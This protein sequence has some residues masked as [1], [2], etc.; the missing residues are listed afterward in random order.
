MYQCN[1]CCYAPELCET[2][3]NY[4]KLYKLRE[5]TRNYAKLCDTMRNYAKLCGTMRNYC[6][7]TI[8]FSLL[9]VYYCI[10]TIVFLLLYFYYCIFL[11]YLV[12]PR[13]LGPPK[14]NPNR[15]GPGP[16]APQAKTK[17][18]RPRTLGPSS[19]TQAGPA[20][21]PWPP[22][23]KPSHSIGNT[24]GKLIKLINKQVI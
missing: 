7:C 5:T 24:I 11:F 22:K 15:S 16:L 6:I 1:L 10:F 19:Q 17:P 3:R 21:D 12:R 20:Q 18:V 13:T 9:Y 8:V 2:M 14:P 4:A 23:P